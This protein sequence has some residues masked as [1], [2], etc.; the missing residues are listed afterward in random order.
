MDRIWGS[1]PL[2]PGVF[3]G[4][5]PC[6]LNGASIPVCTTT[7][8]IDQ[9]RVLT[10]Q[11]PKE[12]QLLS[13]VSQYAAVGTQNYRGLK[14]SFRRRAGDGISL[15]GNYTLSHCMTD[16]DVSGKFVQFA[17]GYLDPKNPRL[18]HN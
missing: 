10:L 9:R 3:L 13:F 11:N 2:N 12:G 17:D 6:V 16:T 18:R 7:A 8:N 15:S 1:V 4:L 5:G 14:L